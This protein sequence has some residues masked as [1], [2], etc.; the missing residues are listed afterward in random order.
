MPTTTYGAL[1]EAYSASPMTVPGRYA[2][3]WEEEQ[4]RGTEAGL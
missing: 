1:H 4:T 2:W 3:T